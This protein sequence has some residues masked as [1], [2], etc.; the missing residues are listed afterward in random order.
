V[1][2]E[3]ADL[4]LA[5][6]GKHRIH[7]PPPQRFDDVFPGHCIGDGT[8]RFPRRASRRFRIEHRGDRGRKRVGITRWHGPSETSRA[9]QI[10]E[11]VALGT[12]DGKA[13]PEVVEHPGAEGIAR[14]EVRVMG[15]HAEVGFHKVQCALV[16]GHPVVEDH[17]RAGDAE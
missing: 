5:V 10:A 16:V 1:G 15:T 8:K 12:H 3:C 7:A 13:R 6:G 2:T 11:M 17:V 9:H 14:L 4:V